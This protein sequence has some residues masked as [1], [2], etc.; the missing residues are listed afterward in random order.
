[1]KK[2][3]SQ[4]RSKMQPEDKPSPKA[5]SEAQNMLHNALTITIKINKAL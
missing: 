4:I 2:G 5:T 3:E 1:M